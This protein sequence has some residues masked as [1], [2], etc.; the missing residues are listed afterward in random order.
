[1]PKLNLKEREEKPG[2]IRIISLVVTS[3]CNLSCSYCYEKNELR[4]NKIMPVSLAKEAI[5]YYMKEKDSD[6]LEIHFFGGEPL[7]GFPFIRD[8]VDWFHYQSFEKKH[9]FLIGTNGTI[10]NEEIKKWLYRNRRCVNVGLSID[11]TKIAHDLSRSNSYDAVKKNLPF[12]RKYWSK[13]PAKMTI[14]ADTIPYVADSVIEMEEMGLNFTANV[15]FEDQWGD[16]SKKAKLLEIYENQLF[17]LIN[18]YDEHPHLYPVTPML[19][20]VPEYLGITS[21]SE[22]KEKKNKITRYCGAGHE[23]VVIDVDGN[24]YPCHRFI[25]W[26]TNKKAP[27]GDVNCQ[28]AWKPDKCAQ[29]KLILSC[30]TCAGFNWE[31]NGDTGTRTTYHC[32]A[33]KLEVMASCL[34]EWKRLRQQKENIDNLEKKDKIRM[35]RRLSAIWEL[36]EN[37][38]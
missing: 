10:L 23:M 36:I 4:D 6:M 22:K 1:M 19:T 28:T 32:E 35:E 12:F 15:A 26:I 11:G 33:F 37:G 14:C 27:S 18:Y 3:A 13:Q 8:V 30:P 20:A 25:P 2:N 24:R 29:C 7:L 34:L 31:T 16:E 9:R 38:I 5:D 21:F 17:R